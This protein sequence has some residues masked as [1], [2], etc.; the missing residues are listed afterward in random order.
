MASRLGQLQDGALVVGRLDQ[1]CANPHRGAGPGGHIDSGD[2][3][4]PANVD[5]PANQGRLRQTE[6]EASI[7]GS[8]RRARECGM[9]QPQSDASLPIPRQSPRVHES[10]RLYAALMGELRIP[11]GPF[12]PKAPIRTP[13]KRHRSNS[14]PISSSSVGMYA[15]VCARL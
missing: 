15:R 9:L 5:D 13:E 2:V 14:C 11:N 1:P 6:D 4:R 3:R 10:C 7:V 12:M 8:P